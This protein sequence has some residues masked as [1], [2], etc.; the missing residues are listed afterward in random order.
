LFLCDIYHDIFPFTGIFLN[1]LSDFG[2]AVTSG[3]ENKNIKLSGT[4]GYAAPEFLLDGMQVYMTSKLHINDL[5][6]E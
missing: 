4:L 5:W 1:Q 3:T 6:F 2:L